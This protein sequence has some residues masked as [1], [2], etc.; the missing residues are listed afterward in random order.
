V[1]VA[2]AHSVHGHSAPTFLHFARCTC[3]VCISCAINSTTAPPSAS[4]RFCS[5]IHKDAGNRCG[6]KVSKVYEKEKEAER[7][8]GVRLN[9]LPLLR[10]LCV[11]Y[12]FAI[13]RDDDGQVLR[14]WLNGKR[15]ATHRAWYVT[16]AHRRACLLP[17]VTRCVQNC[18][19]A[20]S[21]TRRCLQTTML[22]A[23][24]Q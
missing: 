8:G 12:I 13:G 3:P 11:V 22:L 20:V 7:E 23:K 4:A 21:V 19:G 18:A 17:H 15:C 5:R 1:N 24:K 16:L 14:R 10:V 2:C 9:A 6:S